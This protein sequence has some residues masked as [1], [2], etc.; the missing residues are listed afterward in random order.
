MKNAEKHH[1]L[2]ALTL[3]FAII[4]FFSLIVFLG[5]IALIALILVN[6]GALEEFT[7]DIS[8][9]SFVVFLII[10]LS[11]LLGF[12]LS[13][14]VSRILARPL[15]IITEA[16]HDLTSGNY[17]VRLDTDSA[18]C[19]FQAMREYVDSFNSLADELDHTEILRSDFVNN[20]SHEFKTPIVSIAGFAK[21]LKRGNLSPEQMQEYTDIIEEESLRLS[22]MATNMLNLTKVENQTILTD[23]ST[24]NLSEQIRGCVLLLEEKWTRKSLELGLGFDEYEI[25]ANEDMLRQVWINLLDNA[26]KF[27][28]DYGTVGITIRQAAGTTQV[29]ISNTGSTIAP[30]DRDR[31]FH[32]FFQADESH[33]AEGNGIGLAIVQKIVDLHNGRV[34]IGGDEY[35]T[36]FT[37]EL[38]N[39]PLAYEKG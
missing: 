24:F 16:M 21:L 19:R 29:S 2:A 26:V 7:I 36:V 22:D 15:N 11:V 34:T 28:E 35:H 38:P 27:A 10:L 4:I 1:S 20:F 39:A 23:V 12:G 32:K 25:S 33:S 6:T 30:E 3:F 8:A 37:V 5:V 17:K 18:F 14:L 31:I 13:L 9:S